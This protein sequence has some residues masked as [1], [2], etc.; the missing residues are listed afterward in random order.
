MALPG[1]IQAPSLVCQRFT[2]RK[3]PDRVFDPACARCA[4]WMRGS[5]SQRKSIELLNLNKEIQ[6]R[7]KYAEMQ[8]TLGFT[9]LTMNAMALIAPGVSVADFP[10]QATTGATGR[11]CGGILLACCYAWPRQSVTRKWPSSIPAPEVRTISRNNLSSTTKGVALCAPIKFIVGW[12]S[13]LYYWIYPGVMVAVMGVFCG[14][15]VGTLWPNSMSASNPGP[16]F[17]VMV[18]IVFSFA[19]AY[20][21]H[22]GVNGR[23]PS[24]SPST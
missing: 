3:T 1:R 4:G 2:Q 14:Y 21:A 22:R 6:W 15:L 8:P 13:H 17:M 11:R 23:R 12:G 24:T 9:G 7:K 18:A 20:I 16:M 5:I 19:V 10:I